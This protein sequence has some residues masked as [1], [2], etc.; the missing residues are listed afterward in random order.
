MQFFGCPTNIGLD[1][2]EFNGQRI[3]G[4]LRLKLMF[5][6]FR[7]VDLAPNPIRVGFTEPYWQYQPWL[8]LQN[9]RGCA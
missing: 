5:L 6:Q 8:V 1:S 4:A 7:I 2:L 3:Y 9:K